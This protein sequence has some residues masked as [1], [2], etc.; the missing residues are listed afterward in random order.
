V[1]L[2][3]VAYTSNIELLIAT[4]MLTTCKPGTPWEHYKELKKKPEIAEKLVKNIPLKHGS[5]L[6]HNRII[7]IV[8]GTE[9]EILKLIYENRFFEASKLSDNLWILSA[10]LRAVIDY[11]A[12]GEDEFRRE[13]LDS[14]RYLAPNIWRR[15]KD[16]S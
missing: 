1:K 3:L 4:A 15:I 13:L 11:T 14:I 8:E 2:Q 10:N 6:E 16:G 9:N 12:S 7:W 5:V